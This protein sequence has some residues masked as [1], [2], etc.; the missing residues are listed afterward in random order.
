MFLMQVRAD[1]AMARM[2][3]M[4]RALRAKFSTYPVP[5]DLLLSTAGAVLVE[6]SQNDLFWG[7]GRSGNG[8]NK[9]GLLL[10]QLR[11]QFLQDSEALNGRLRTAGP[12]TTMS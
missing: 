4:E 7:A 11:S 2:S 3:A 5:R 6:A 10:M 8:E 9:L 12:A 1:W